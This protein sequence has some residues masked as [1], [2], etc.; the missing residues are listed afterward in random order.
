MPD[1]DR[2]ILVACH[3]GPRAS[4]LQREYKA[5]GDRFDFHGSLLSAEGWTHVQRKNTSTHYR[6]RHGKKPM[7]L[8][9]REVVRLYWPPGV[10]VD[11]R[12]PRERRDE[13]RFPRNK[14]NRAALY[15]M[16]VR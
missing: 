6:F 16:G 7:A 14:Q 1:L 8:E 2:F 11:P 5:H 9:L 15:A 13:R 12:T 4:I 10:K 3:R